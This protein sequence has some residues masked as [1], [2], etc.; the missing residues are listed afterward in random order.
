VKNADNGQNGAGA[1]WDYSNYVGSDNILSG[2]ETS[3]AR[4]LQFNNPTNEPFTV[5]FNVIGNLARSSSTSANQI[6]TESG[7]TNDSVSGSGND[8][9]A[10]VTNLVFKVTY[11]PLLNIVTVQL[12]TP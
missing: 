8:P 6:S 10:I 9:T 12:V 4:L 7:G 1:L 3:G 2:G 11:N 5:T